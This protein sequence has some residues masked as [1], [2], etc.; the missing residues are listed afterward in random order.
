MGSAEFP[1]T[2]AAFFYSFTHVHSRC[3]AVPKMC[4]F[5]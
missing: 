1:V 2:A 5:V 4:V 3:G